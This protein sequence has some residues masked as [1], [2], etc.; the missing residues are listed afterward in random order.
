MKNGWALGLGLVFASLFVAP[1]FG[2][3][4]APAPGQALFEQ[5]CAIC[6]KADGSG[7]PP[8]FPALAGNQNLSDLA[9]IVTN[10]HQGKGAMPPFPNLTAEEIA[11]I[12]TYVRT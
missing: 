4:A 11:T 9:L 10:V 7:T 12:A 6:H 2:Q 3:A 1:A 5:N 8:I